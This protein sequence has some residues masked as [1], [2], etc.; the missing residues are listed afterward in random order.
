MQARLALLAVATMTL[1]LTACGGGDAPTPASLHNLE[2]PPCYGLA[3]M[4]L[5]DLSLALSRGD[6]DRVAALLAHDGEFVLTGFAT[7]PQGW[8]VEAK[9]EEVKATDVASAKALIDAAQGARWALD[10]QL[11]ISIGFDA[12]PASV[13][14]VRWRAIGG[15]VRLGWF[16]AQ[17]EGTGK[18]AFDCATARFTRVL[19]GGPLAVTR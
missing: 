15:F 2:T 5:Q 3:A 9:G 10:P 17:V 18:A 7:G 8:L 16:A 1:A 12:E 14:G 6:A 13:L 11:S 19:L 4:A